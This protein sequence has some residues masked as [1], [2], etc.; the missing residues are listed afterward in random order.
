LLFS[1][2]HVPSFVLAL[3]V[4]LQLPTQVHSAFV[5]VRQV[6]LGFSFGPDERSLRRRVQGSILDSV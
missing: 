3:S 1:A 4:A 2:S 5:G 6:D